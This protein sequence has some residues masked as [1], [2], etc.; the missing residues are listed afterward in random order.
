MTFAGVCESR[1]NYGIGLRCD[2]EQT[3]HDNASVTTN[4][5]DMKDKTV[6]NLGPN[7]LLDSSAS[8]LK[9]PDSS[10]PLNQRRSVSVLVCLWSDVSG[11]P[12]AS[13][14]TQYW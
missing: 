5:G 9:C 11:H 6:W 10:D 1:C 7:C 4:T 8:V 14:Q 2:D 12:S 13:L 3:S